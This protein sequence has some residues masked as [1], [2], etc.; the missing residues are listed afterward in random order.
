MQIRKNGYNDF[1]LLLFIAQKI[2]K[3]IICISTEMLGVGR[4]SMKD[5]RFAVI[6]GDRRS[7]EL[8]K[9]LLSKGHKVNLY[10]FKNLEANNKIDEMDTISS[11]ISNVDIVVAPV[12]ISKDGIKINTP[13]DERD[14]LIEDIFKSMNEHQLFIGGKVSDCLDMSKNY[15]IPVIDILDRE[16]MAVLNA[17]PTAEGAIQIA[18]EE[19]PI[20]LHGSNIMILGFG[21]IGKVLAKMLRGMGSNVYV[22]ARKHSDISWIKAYDYYPIYIFDLKEK[23]SHMNLIINTIPK[24]LINEELLKRINNETLII[25]LASMPGGINYYAADKM[26]KKVIH[27][28]ALPGK[29]A[30]VSS[31]EFM[32]D[33]IYNIIEEEGV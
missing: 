13:Y 32:L 26:G 20:T 22:L 19:I 14:I 6:G 18:L 2:H 21:R 5:K 17:I 24:S 15:Q 11:A 25:D 23:L 30:P 29:M 7:Y 33:T 1:G 12:P 3:Y 27:A 9:L 16:E 10:G 31:A 4:D 8:A 28:L